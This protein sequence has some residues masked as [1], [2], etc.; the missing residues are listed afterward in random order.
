MTTKNKVEEYSEK[1]PLEL[2]SIFKT[3]PQD[4]IDWALVTYLLKY[5]DPHCDIIFEEKNIV[6]IKKVAKWFNL[7]YKDVYKRL[8]KMLW[9]V[10]IGTVYGYPKPFTVCNITQIGSDLIMKMLDLYVSKFTEKK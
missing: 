10:S 7:E 3:T 2:R 1:I 5:S 6:T 8:N 4:D 9:W